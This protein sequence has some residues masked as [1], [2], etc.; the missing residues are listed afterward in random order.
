MSELVSIII[1][2]YNCAT[3]IQPAL[4]SV[5]SQ[6]H[7]NIELILVDD[8]ST[9]N[10]YELLKLFCENHPT[11][12][13]LIQ[14]PKNSGPSVARNVGLMNASGDYIAFLDSDDEWHPDKTALQLAQFKSDNRIVMSSTSCRLKTD[15]TDEIINLEKEGRIRE[16]W[17]VLFYKNIVHTSCAMIRKDV[18]LGEFFRTDLA[19]SEDREFWLRI[20]RKGDIGYLASPLTVINRI[21]S[22]M[23]KNID[24]MLTDFLPWIECVVK[25][26][27]SE[28]TFSERN[29]ALGYAYNTAGINLRM[30]GEYW[31]SIPYSLKSIVRGF[32]VKNNIMT[33][34]AACPPIKFIRR[35]LKS[36]Y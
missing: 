28:M 11:K 36:I 7:E 25:Q 5:C 14:L 10:T 15:D 19:V 22:Y 2:T 17:K 21:D 16:G 31:K 6:T 8:C 34:I 29:R 26:L 13:K 32:Q 33:L 23:E 18:M 3:Y 4:D 35:Y 20:V 27:S 9:D 12:T 30:R 1:P 24:K